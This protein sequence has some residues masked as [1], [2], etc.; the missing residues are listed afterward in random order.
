MKGGRW[1]ARGGEWRRVDG[2]EEEIVERRRREGREDD[3]GRKRGRWRE[4]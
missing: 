1:E 4:K 3:T 2:K